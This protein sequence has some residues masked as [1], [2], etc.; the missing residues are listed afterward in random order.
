MADLTAAGI[1]RRRE[2]LLL[3]LYDNSDASVLANYG[4][5]KKVRWRCGKGH[6][7]EA[8]VASRF[9]GSG[10]PY[11]SGRLAIPGETDLATLRPDLARELVDSSLGTTL[12][13]GSH[14][15]V[16]WR[17][18]KGHVWEATVNDRSSGRGCPYCS[19][20]RVLVGETDLA[21]VR[22]DLASQLVD[23]SLATKLM[24]SSS[25][26]VTW[27]CEHG[28]VWEATVAN[29]SRGSGCPYCAG[30]RAEQGATDLA[31]LRPD[32]ACEL[33]DKSLA[34]KLM[35]GSDQKV[36]WECSLGHRWFA[37]VKQRNAGTGCPYCSGNKV[38][39]GFNDLATTHPEVAKQLVNPED[40]KTVTA[41]SGQKLRWRCENGHEW[42]AV[43]AGRVHG[44]GCPICNR[45][46]R[47]AAERDLI[48]CVR[49]L[50]GD[51]VEV[52]ENDRR[53]IAP[54]ELDVVI[55]ERKVA[56]EFN[57][58]WWHGEE[59]GCARGYHRDKR[60]ATKAVGY[61]LIQVWEDDWRLRHN[62]VL[63]MLA[64]KLGC[65]DRLVEVGVDVG[66]ARRMFA[67]KLICG[68]LD[69]KRA[70]A[71]LDENHIQGAVVATRHF[72]LFSEDE[73]VA[74]LS[75]RSPRHNARMR[76]GSG[77]WEVQRYA[78]ACSVVGGFSRLLAYAERTLVAEGVDLVR[79]ISFSACDV[80]D[81]D[82]YTKCG[83]SCDGEIGPDYR[84]A[85]NRTG[86]VRVPKEAFQKSRFRRDE[87]LVFDESWTEREAASANGL[88]RCFDSG[89]LRWVRDVHVWAHMTRS[90]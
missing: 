88:W 23:A 8:K 15:R 31:T 79:W 5:Q 59:S 45:D 60:L 29:R 48:E 77:E 24:V 12:R 27:R 85:G 17:C 61:R 52:I 62:V 84:Y 33:V 26:R 42:D 9:R 70:G 3:E 51:G 32:L 53:L 65:E 54:Q 80:S 78:T 81:G 67:R 83:F 25:K 10:C 87:A 66:H 46:K 72:A 56:I 6:V 41:G 14:K 35:S 76:R 11:C 55:P 63:R 68:E 19:R 50:V 39:V 28:H 44:I 73:P 4:S 1:A 34:T 82:M 89:K 13:P 7:W 86:G 71:F 75:V 58:V 2:E 22:P 37:T 40:A 36:E 16:E 90:R 30:K 18:E 43:V 20:K 69:A 74:V 57:G 21:T 38:M 64:A 47:S 49:K